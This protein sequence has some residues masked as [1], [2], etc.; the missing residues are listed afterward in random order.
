MNRPMIRRI[1]ID[2]HGRVCLQFQ[3]RESWCDISRFP[4]RELHPRKDP[5]IPLAEEARRRDLRI[6]GYRPARRLVASGRLDGAAAVWKGYRRGK[7]AQHARN[8]ALAAS[9][10]QG[11][12]VGTPTLLEVDQGA[13][14]LVMRGEAGLRPTVADANAEDF[15]RMG[16]GA[17]QLQAFRG[18]MN[19]LV[20]FGRDDELGVLQERVRRLTAAGGEPP[21]GWTQLSSALADAASVP[22]S[23]EPV[24]CHRDLH[25]GQ[26][27]VDQGRPC[28]LDFDLLCRAEPEVDAANF[29]AHLELR[30]LQH[31]DAIT[32]RDVAACGEAFL[33][34]LGFGHS[35][36]RR[37]RLAFYQATT[38]AR[39]ALVYHLRPRWQGLVGALAGLGRARL[40]DLAGAAG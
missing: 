3:D 38:F 34:G 36:G 2:K 26:W 23:A 33:D 11:D 22:P 12:D 5:R 9:A 32:A 14:F 18:D 39:L 37:A 27:L 16:A 6:L 35:P 4:P 13:D 1:E 40:E 19:A 7:G 30:R 24:L 20:E 17:R 15:L 31:P 8:Y 21:E 29:L 28:L 25:D 10:L